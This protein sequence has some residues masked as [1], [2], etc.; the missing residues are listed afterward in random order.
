MEAVMKE[1]ID[2][3]KIKNY[4]KE[5]NL[6]KA[7]FCKKCGISP[8]SLN[9]V[10]RGSVNVDIKLLFKIAWAMDLHVKDM[11]VLA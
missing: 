4:I 6:S 1:I 2:V 11:F 9:K 7:S 5:H 3:Q 10:I 8:Q